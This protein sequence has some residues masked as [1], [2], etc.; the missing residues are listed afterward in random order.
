MLLRAVEMLEHVHGYLDLCFER[1]F[2]YVY[3]KL[4]QYF[5]LQVYVVHELVVI[6]LLIFGKIKINKEL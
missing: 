4:C 6:Y 5:G 1:K 2:E 3:G